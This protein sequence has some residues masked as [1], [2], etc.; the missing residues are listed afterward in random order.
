VN[1]AENLSHTRSSPHKQP[2]SRESGSLASE[3]P[4][5]DADA[6]RQ[7]VVAHD[8]GLGL[9]RHDTGDVGGGVAD[10]AVVGDRRRARVAA[11][12][13]ALV[14]VLG[15]RAVQERDGLLAE[16]V[17]AFEVIAVR[18]LLEAA[19]VHDVRAPLPRHEF[20]AAL[21]VRAHLLAR[22]LVAL[23]GHVPR[24]RIGSHDQNP[25]GGFHV[26]SGE[27]LAYA[28]L[29]AVLGGGA[30]A[31]LPLRAAAAGHLDVIRGGRWCKLGAGA[32]LGPRVHD[33][34]DGAGVRVAL[35]GL[36]IVRAGLAAEGGLDLR[37]AALL[38]AGVPFVGAAR[39]GAG[40]PGA[41]GVG[42]AVGGARGGVAV[43][44]LL[45]ERARVTAVGGLAGD[46]AGARL[47]A[48]AARLGAFGPGTER[49]HDAVRGARTLAALLALHERGARHAAVLGVGARARLRLRAGTAGLGAGGPLAVPLAHDGVNGAGVL[50]ALLALREC[51]ACLAAV[52][53]LGRA[54]AR[55][56]LRAGAAGL[57]AVGP[58]A[59]PVAHDA[60]DGA[61]VLVAVLLV[62]ERRAN[63][64]IVLVLGRDLAAAALLAALAGQ[65]ARAPLAPCGHLAVDGAGVVRV[66]GLR[67]VELLRGAL[68]LGHSFIIFN[69][70]YSLS[71]PFF[72]THIKIIVAINYLFNF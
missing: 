58:C 2:H 12:A 44:D 17:L 51:G 1:T 8:V 20:V 48:G 19:V 5:L 60:I 57:A 10:D 67:L 56:R 63:I 27:L 45:E 49:G 3:R 14:L 61:L 38:R 54:L 47:R 46:G 28:L 39:L 71:Q 29:T 42:D 30:R 21:G 59:V 66:A 7:D 62:L 13:D 52:F 24:F 72:T 64:A 6:A 34:I 18:L 22:G 31:I 40:G 26:P 36:G 4:P 53:G 43:A 25:T 33:G 68:V 35:P 23:P 69:I 41:E 70:F 37:A 55:L 50:V 16:V 9:A 15:R 65:G 32:P 11:V